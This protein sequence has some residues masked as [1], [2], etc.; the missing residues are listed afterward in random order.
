VVLDF[1]N[2]EQVARMIEAVVARVT[3]A[4]GGAQRR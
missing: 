1:E 4:R 2:P 3:V